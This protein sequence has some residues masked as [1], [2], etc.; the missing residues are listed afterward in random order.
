MQPII[1]AMIPEDIMLID[2][3]QSV[4]WSH[5]IPGHVWQYWKKPKGSPGT[6]LY[7]GDCVG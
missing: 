6:R 5:A 3:S 4:C 2:S 1:I 7:L